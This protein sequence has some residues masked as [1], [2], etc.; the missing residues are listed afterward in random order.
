MRHF[1]RYSTFL[2][3]A[4]TTSVLAGCRPTPASA[5]VPVAV[6]T[7]APAS[8]VPANIR[9]TRASAEHRALF[10]QTYGLAAEQLQRVAAGRPPGS[11]GV[12]MDADETLLDNSLYEQELA[13]SGRSYTDSSWAAW[14]RSEAAPA[15][16][17]AV[18]FT[19]RVHDLGGRVAIV[20]GRADALCPETRAN[21]QRVGI[22]FDEVL[23]QAG[24]NSDK[25]PRFD[26]VIQGRAPST[27]PAM[28]VVMWVGD[29]IQDFPHTVQ[30]IRL[31]PD[32]AFSS[33]GR[34][35]ILL[36][37]PLYGSWEKNPLPTP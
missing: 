32:S 7:P 8:T 24:S 4:A 1:R 22:T 35:Y 17:G 15:L 13:E 23:C 29:N 20:T 12:I 37:D 36:P 21:L 6:A 2:A 3:I 25:N 11:W 14:V 28:D 5:P 19:R 30:G 26:A 18:Q 10:L 31:E 27:L 16:P 34:R 33:F 9:W